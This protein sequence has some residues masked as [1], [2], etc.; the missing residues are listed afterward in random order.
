MGSKLGQNGLFQS[1][2][3]Q[4]LELSGSERAHVLDLEC[5]YHSEQILFPKK[6]HVIIWV[7]H[8][9]GGRG[10]RNTWSMGKFFIVH[11][12]FNNDPMDH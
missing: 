10:V 7:M 2:F 5:Q 6:F 1:C 11:F 12:F 4:Y 9:N 3:A 8:C